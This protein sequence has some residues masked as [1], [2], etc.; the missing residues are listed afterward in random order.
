M[1]D[2]AVLVDQAVLVDEIGGEIARAGKSLV[3]DIDLF[4]YYEGDTIP[5]GKKSL[6]FRIVY[7]S[8]RRTLT[9]KEID[10]LQNKIAAALAARGWEVR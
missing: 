6:A 3:R 1:R 7:Q 5:E 2:I 8:D 9:S 10:A 4:D